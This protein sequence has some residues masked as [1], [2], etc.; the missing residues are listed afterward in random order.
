MTAVTLHLLALTSCG[1]TPDARRHPRP[2]VSP[3]TPADAPRGGHHGGARRPGG[4]PPGGPAG[5][6]RGRRGRHRRPAAALRP[7]PA[8][9]H[10]RDRLLGQRP[11]RHAGR[12]RHL[13]RQPGA[14]PRRRRRPREA[15]ERPHGRAVVDHRVDRR[16]H[17][18]EPGGQLLHLR[19][20]QPRRRQPGIGVG[21]PDG[22]GQHLPREHHQPVVE[23]RAQ[24][25]AL[26]GARPRAWRVEDGHLHPDRHYRHALRGR[27]PG[28]A[29]H[30]PELAAQRHRQRHDHQQR[31]R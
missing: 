1:G 21:L 12:R 13:G 29:E 28:R 7:D 26:P 23:Q 17:R 3:D 4:P 30:Q 20:R 10:R 31:A 2:Y 18:A 16:L 15:A 24:H 5:G 11:R 19:P 27:R 8:V 22:L 14:R 6:L 9:R 25:R